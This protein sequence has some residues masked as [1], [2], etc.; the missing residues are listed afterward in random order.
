MALRPCP[1]CGQKI[2]D[3]AVFCPSCGYECNRTWQKKLPYYF[4]I[5]LLAC[6]L[7]TL[8]A[9]SCAVL[10]T[11]VFRQ[12]EDGLSRQ[13]DWFVLVAMSVGLFLFWIS[14]VLAAKNVAWIRGIRDPHL[15]T[16]SYAVS[17]WVAG[18]IALLATLGLVVLAV[19]LLL[20]R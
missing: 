20:F 13:R 9:V 3:S 8:M 16:K 4:A 6:L 10:A 5:Y 7:S 14:V 18:F 2:S 12:H 1:E 15:K 19:D 17:A 11:Y